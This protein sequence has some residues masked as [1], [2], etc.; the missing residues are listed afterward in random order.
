MNGFSWDILHCPLA[1]RCPARWQRLEPIQGDPSIRFCAACERS[2]FLCQSDEDLSRHSALGRCVALEIPSVGVAHI[3][4]PVPDLERYR[5]AEPGN[6]D[7][8]P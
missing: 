2:L 7:V 3:G 6:E 4:E 5:V 1:K 8:D